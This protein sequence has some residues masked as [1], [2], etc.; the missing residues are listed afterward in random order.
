MEGLLD[1][2]FK[3]VQFYIYQDQHEADEKTRYDICPSVLSTAS[4]ITVRAVQNELIDHGGRTCA[5]SSERRRRL[6][7]V[8]G[9]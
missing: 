1:H 3:R 9:G 8:T 7:R 2:Y 6:L 5:S 4:K